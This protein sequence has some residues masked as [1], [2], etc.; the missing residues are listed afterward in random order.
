MATTAKKLAAKQ[1]QEATMELPSS[2]AWL[3]SSSVEL[4]SPALNLSSHLE[5]AA[6]II[7]SL[8][9]TYLNEAE[10]TFSDDDFIPLFAEALGQVR[11]IPHH[12]QLLVQT[13]QASVSFEDAGFPLEFF[14]IEY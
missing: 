14:I 1:R 9:N 6:G 7:I 11:M 3:T 2:P 4:T 8:V 13:I 10:R 12:W 5:V